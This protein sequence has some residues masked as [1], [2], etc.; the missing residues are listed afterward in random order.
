MSRYP[1]DMPIEPASRPERLED[2]F[3]GEHYP[4][5]TE[6]CESCAVGSKMVR[7]I[8]DVLGTSRAAL[9]SEQVEQG[10]RLIREWTHG[11]S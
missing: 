1:D 6:P 8:L 7:W 2:E 3:F 4:R 9:T 10:G 11:A 5:H